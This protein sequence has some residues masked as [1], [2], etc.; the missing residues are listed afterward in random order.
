MKKLLIIFGVFVLMLALQIQFTQVVTAADDD[1]DDI[2]GSLVCQY[3]SNNDTY[4]VSTVDLVET[5]C[6]LEEVPDACDANESCSDCLTALSLLGYET[7][8]SSEITNNRVVY[9]LTDDC[10]G[11]DGDDDDDDSGTGTGGETDGP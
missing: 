4:V 1:D 9:S 7:D 5:E 8:K 3:K 2:V 6:G 11:D 10:G